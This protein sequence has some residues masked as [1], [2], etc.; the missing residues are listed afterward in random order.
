MMDERYHS[1]VREIDALDRLAGS[2]QYC[3]A[4]KL[5]HAQM[6]AIRLTRMR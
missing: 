1:S 6:P 3:T 4:L 2:V 5:D